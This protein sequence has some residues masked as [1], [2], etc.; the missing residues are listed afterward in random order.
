MF[1]LWGY[2]RL[3][4]LVEV[5]EE[6]VSRYMRTACIWKTKSPLAK[7]LEFLEC[8]DFHA[9][10][11]F[12][13]TREFL[14]LTEHTTVGPR[15][16]LRRIPASALYGERPS[17]VLVP[18]QYVR[19]HTE[20]ICLYVGSFVDVLGKIRAMV[21]ST[22]P[23][24]QKRTRGKRTPTSLHP[25]ALLPWLARCPAQ[26]IRSISSR[27]ILCRVFVVPALFVTQENEI[28]HEGYLL[29]HG[30][31]NWQLLHQEDHPFE[32]V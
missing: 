22:R 12:A 1:S 5:E 27:S 17:I 3:L 21:I 31:F 19:L 30:I 18:G 32:D 13:A 28:S 6:V 14:R 15:L 11:T 29:V 2:S 26:D 9:A 8:V 7:I 4:F 25:G 23:Y 16:Q 10:D 24:V 20:E